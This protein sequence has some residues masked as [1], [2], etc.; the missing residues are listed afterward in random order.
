MTIINRSLLA[1]SVLA[2]ASAC[3]D[4]NS[5]PAADGG[6]PVVVRPVL[7]SGT[8]DSGVIVTPT[9]DGGTPVAPTTDSGTPVTPGDC[10][11]GTPMVMTDFLN[12]CTSAQ[13][14]TK[15][16]AVPSALLTADGGVV[17]L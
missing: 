3:G 10:F 2:L 5:S 16:L 12:R 6:P 7:D 15:T 14:T 1:L 13:T 9:T 8:P 4:D 11:T 17:P